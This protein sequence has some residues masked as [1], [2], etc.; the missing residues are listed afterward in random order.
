MADKRRQW[1]FNV[2]HLLQ[3]QSY[4]QGNDGWV[5][6]TQEELGEI[7]PTFHERQ[8]IG[9]YLREMRDDGLVISEQRSANKWDQTLSWKIVRCECHEEKIPI[10]RNI[11][12]VKNAQVQNTQKTP[13]NRS[14][15]SKNI[16]QKK[17]KK[18]PPLI[19]P[20]PLAIPHPP[21]NPPFP[22]KEKKDFFVARETNFQSVSAGDLYNSLPFRFIWSHFNSINDETGFVCDHSDLDNQALFWLNCISGNSQQFQTLTAFHP[23]M[24]TQLGLSQ[25]LDT[26]KSVDHSEYSGRI[27]SNVVPEG[28]KQRLAETGRPMNLIKAELQT[29]LDAYNTANGNRYRGNEE[30]A[31]YLD[32]WR[33][34]YTLDEIIEAAEKIPDDP[35]WCDKMTPTIFFRIQNPTKQPVDYIGTFL[36]RKFDKYKKLTEFGIWEASYKT[37]VMIPEVMTTYR[38]IENAIDDGSIQKWGKGR[39]TFDILLA[40]IRYDL[41]RGVIRGASETEML[42][43]NDGRPDEK[44]AYTIVLET[45]TIKAI[46]KKAVEYREKFDELPEG[47]EKEEYRQKLRKCKRDHADCVASRREAVKKLEYWRDR[48]DR[49]VE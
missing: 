11:L 35:F 39:N 40:E 45:E 28:K 19:P 33:T 34:V 44:Y 46:V 24:S 38:R 15:V 30:L 42:K 49:Y 5:C 8:M 20:S 14:V 4:N 3:D 47:P 31:K 12:P 43:L 37:G 25:T 6:I 27:L 41:T 26:A 17:K 1:I 21:Y 10:H 29:F 16:L 13:I 23:N 32:H 18:F 2:L 48:D 7:C 22:E 36:S 9:K